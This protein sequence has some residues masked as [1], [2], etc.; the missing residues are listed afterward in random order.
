MNNPT[1][2]FCVKQLAKTYSS[3]SLLGRN[4]QKE[5][6]SDINLNIAKGETLGLVGCSGSGKSTLRRLWLGLEKPSQGS[7]EFNG[8]PMASF[9]D[10]DWRTFRQQVQIVFQDSI[11]AV[12]P[13]LTVN[14]IIEE[15]LLH[16]TELDKN[17]RK[18]RIQELLKLVE[19]TPE[20][21]KKVPAQM[22]GGM[23]QRVC[24]SRALAPNPKVIALDESLS[25]L[26]LMLQQQLIELLKDIQTVSGTAYLFIT[27]DLRLVQKFC[28]RAIVLADGKI[29]ED[30]SVGKQMQFNSEAGKELQRAILPAFPKINKKVHVAPKE[31]EPA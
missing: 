11:S 12:N 16:L 2:L 14:E 17:A 25:S 18:Q 4:S 21:G 9:S 31:R 26:D 10:D 1:P 3:F 30:L 22:S 24:I 27:H 6:L 15:P 23:L 13:R 28:H 29:Q 20:D 5:V 8:K 7:I 19:L